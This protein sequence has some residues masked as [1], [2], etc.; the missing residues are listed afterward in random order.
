MMLQSIQPCFLWKR[1]RWIVKNTRST[2]AALSTTNPKKIVYCQ[3]DQG[4]E[5]RDKL[6]FFFSSLNWQDSSSPQRT[7]GWTGR[8][9]QPRMVLYKQAIAQIMI[10]S[11]TSIHDG[12]KTQIWHF[13]KAA[14]TRL[15]CTTKCRQ[16]HWTRWSF[17]QVT[18]CSTGNPRLQSSWRWLLTTKKKKRLKKYAKHTKKLKKKRKK[19]KKNTHTH[20]KKKTKRKTR[21]QSGREGEKGEEKITWHVSKGMS[22]NVDSFFFSRCKI[23]GEKKSNI[24]QFTYVLFYTVF[25]KRFRRFSAWSLR[26]TSFSN[27]SSVSFFD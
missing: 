10:V 16:A 5:A 26:S 24:V 8:D 7:I 13:I 12:L 22:G 17:L 23:A 15:L 21:T 20:T 9:Y 18:C 4:W 25:E 3:E 11:I 2:R 1:Y 6:V 27:I 19:K 14:M